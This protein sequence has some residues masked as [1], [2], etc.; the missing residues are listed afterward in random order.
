MLLLFSNTK[1]IGSAVFVSA[2]TWSARVVAK[3]SATRIMVG[4]ASFLVETVGGGDTWLSVHR[5]VFSKT[6]SPVVDLL[7]ASASWGKKL[8]QG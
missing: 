4:E 2:Q 6:S 7:I 8:L 5:L 3:S 1:L